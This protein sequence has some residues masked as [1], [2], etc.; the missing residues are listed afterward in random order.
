MMPVVVNNDKNLN[1]CGGGECADFNLQSNC[2]I[3]KSIN[4]GSN[5]SLTVTVDNVLMIGAHKAPNSI[6]TIVPQHGSPPGSV[7]DHVKTNTQIFPGNQYSY[8]CHTSLHKIDRSNYTFVNQFDNSHNQFVYIHNYPQNTP[9]GFYF[10]NFSYHTGQI[11]I[12]ECLSH[13]VDILQVCDTIYLSIYPASIKSHTSHTKRE[14]KLTYDN[15][16]QDCL[17]YQRYGTSYETYMNNIISSL[18]DAQ[19]DVNNMAANSLDT[20][21]NSCKSVDN[22]SIIA[23]VHDAGV[24]VASSD[25]RQTC[26][27]RD[28]NYPT[29]FKGYI[30]KQPTEF[31]FIGP[32]RPGIGTNDSE[33]YLKLAR[34]IRESGVPNY[35]Q[36]RV[37]IKSG[38]NIEAWRHHLSDYKDQV[39][40][41]YLEY[42]FPLS[43]RDSESLTDLNTM[44]HFSAKQLYAPSIKL[45]I[46]QYTVHLCSQDQR[47]LTSVASYLICLTQKG[48]RL[49]TK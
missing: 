10:L 1:L 34:T 19:G 3:S 22:G 46:L 27:H 12:L 42:G 36:V 39:L 20:V 17:S 48:H 28:I 14:A 35:R 41:Q 29:K 43:I 49:M 21:S 16:N 25:K 15:Y 31:K 5:A 23:I 11:T 32:D 6:D 26:Q 45:T 44:N 47:T 38:L 13:P 18:I 8:G 33:Q 7:I 2:H 9:G 40:I 24:N 4:T 30:A 37:P